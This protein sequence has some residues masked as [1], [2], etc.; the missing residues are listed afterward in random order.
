[1]RAG[2]LLAPL[3]GP[4]ALSA[5]LLPASCAR[6]PQASLPSPS[7]VTILPAADAPP[8]PVG[9]GPVTTDPSTSLPPSTVVAT[10]SYTV[11]VGDTLSGIA[12]QFGT[13]FEVLVALNDLQE[14]G[15]L[16]VGQVLVVPEPPP[17]TAPPAT[18]P[19]GTSEP[20][21]GPL[22]NDPAGT[23]GS[24]TTLPPATKEG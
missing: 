10:L 5:L 6:P 12:E 7:T 11:Q 19:P 14:P 18:T 1:M 21:A 20:P 4:V 8:K 9:A 13:S 16:G 23:E 17:T 2:S 22:P 3:L 15:R 24:A